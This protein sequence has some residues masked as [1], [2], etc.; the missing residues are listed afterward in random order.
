MTA[1][2][3]GEVEFNERTRFAWPIVASICGAAV[4]IIWLLA[5]M[6]GDIGRL[7]NTVDGLVLRVEGH[8]ERI[9]RL[10]AHPR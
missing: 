7:V 3:D 10:E 8:T 5:Q 9:T 1:K 2:P 4:P 6:H